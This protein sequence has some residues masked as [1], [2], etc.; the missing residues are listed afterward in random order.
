MGLFIGPFQK[1][2][3]LKST[4]LFYQVSLLGCY[5]LVAS[6]S[7]SIIPSLVIG[8]IFG[9]AM[10]ASYAS[11][12]GNQQAYEV[13]TRG[14][15]SDLS[16]FDFVISNGLFLISAPIFTSI[17]ERW[18]HKGHHG[19]SGHIFFPW[20]IVVPVILAV[21][22]AVAYRRDVDRNKG[23][24]NSALI[25]ERASTVLHRESVAPLSLTLHRKR[26]PAACDSYDSGVRRC[27]WWP[28]V[29]PKQK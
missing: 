20:L 6:Y 7:W 18:Y 12:P 13:A 9:N 19:N 28:N 27:D 16:C 11:F 22:M 24:D 14:G 25:N 29:F 15:P 10:S 2:S 26:V 3:R 17:F 4:C 23:G 5:G 8:V 1:R 21:W